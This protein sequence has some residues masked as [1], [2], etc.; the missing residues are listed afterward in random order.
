[1]ACTPV[2]QGEQIVIAKPED[3]W[4]LHEELLQ[5]LRID[6]WN[7]LGL[8]YEVVNICLG[9]MGTVAARKYDIEAWLP[10]AAQ[11]KEVVS[12]SNCLIIKQ[13]DCR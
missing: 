6:L 7:E 11:Y 13:I 10:G 12:C 5:E 4:E 2:H 9:D 1:M 8:H 3:S